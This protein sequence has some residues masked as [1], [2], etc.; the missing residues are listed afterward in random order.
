M[1]VS[2][3]VKK[4][5]LNKMNHSSHASLIVPVSENERST[6]GMKICRARLRKAA[7]S[8]CF[9]YALRSYYSY[10]LSGITDLSCPVER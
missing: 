1:A 7:E 8:S 3:A 5:S 4:R 9:S 2:T 10:P 6:A